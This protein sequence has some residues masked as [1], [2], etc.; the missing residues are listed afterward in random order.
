MNW[1]RIQTI[2]N[3]DLK[4]AIRDA[5]VLVAIVVPIG[6]GLFYSVAFDDSD[7]T[8][9]SA[10][11]VYAADGQTEL[12]AALAQAVGDNVDLE[13]VPVGSAAE[14]DGLVREDDA[15]L[16][17]AVPAGFDEAA[18][19]GARPALAVYL[20][21]EPGFG[22]RYV[23]AALEPAVRLVAGQ[24]LPAR[25]A[26][27]SPTDEADE[28]VFEQLGIR[29]Y[30][31]LASIIFL[32]VMIAMLV[33]PV[34]LAEEAEK[35]TLDALVLIASYLDVIAA[36]ALLGAAYIALAVALQLGLTRLGVEDVVQF[37][38]AVAVL[39]VALI[40]F[41]LLLGSVFKNANQL[42]TWS[43][44][45]LVP[46]I[47]PVFMVGTP[48]PDLIERLLRLF[49]TSAGMELAINAVAGEEVFHDPWFLYAVLL[50]WA[51]LAYLLLA[52]QLNRRQA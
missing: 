21:A 50:G 39:S 17:F 33:V 20:P 19:A 52:W 12:P 18:R 4:D 26:T 23:A 22:A 2:F 10:T 46:F 16:G 34:V 31:V 13:L 14:A 30:T 43:G 36:K 35:K 7:P 32:V 29:S 28:S 25:I 48:V 47:A 42:N 40:G 51:A 49:P 3:K 11:V 41:G 6:I 9:P 27:A 1:R 38:A 44:F 37:A 15:D 24:Q 45:L 5:R 8:R